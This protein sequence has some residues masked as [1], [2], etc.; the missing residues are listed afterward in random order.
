MWKV[1]FYDFTER[2]LFHGS[3][4]LLDKHHWTHNSSASKVLEQIPKKVKQLRNDWHSNNK[5]VEFFCVCVRSGTS[6]VLVKPLT[7]YTCVYNDRLCLEFFQNFD[8]LN[9]YYR[10]LIDDWKKKLS[11]WNNVMK[12]LKTEDEP[13]QK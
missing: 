3:S 7:C 2:V 5:R 12:V 6:F 8:S 9:C 1:F 13:G 10:L 4:E 11:I